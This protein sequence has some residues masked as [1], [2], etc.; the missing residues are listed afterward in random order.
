MKRLATLITCGV[1]VVVACG[2]G[3]GI[4]EHIVGSGTVATEEFAVEGFTG[5]RACCDFMVIVS[6][7]TGY[8]VSV[9]ADDNVLDYVIVK[10]QG[11]ELR[12]ELD[13]YFGETFEPTVLRANVTMPRLQSVVLSGGAY[14]TL[15]QAAPEGTDLVLTAG[16]GSAAKLAG[17]P[18][19]RAQVTLREKSFADVQVTGHLTYTL[20]GGSILQ[21]EG[22][23]LLGDTSVSGGALAV[24]R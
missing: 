3:A 19:Q 9:T 22:D 2:C 10:R 23:P 18:F 11:D 8:S 21:Y 1:L 4:G 24:P 16:G 12:L 6:G 17:I 13:Q 5:L 7:G 14:L 20:R 15:W